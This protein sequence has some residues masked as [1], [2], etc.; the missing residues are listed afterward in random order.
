MREMIMRRWCD[1]CYAEGALQQEA[2]HTYTVGIVS[3]EGRPAL[4]VLEVCEVHNKTAVELMDLMKE[5]GQLPDLRAKAEPVKPVLAATD[6]PTKECPVCGTGVPR[7]T[8]VQHVWTRH[9]EDEKPAV[10][11]VCPE[12]RMPIDNGSGMSAHRRS[13]HGHSALD[14]ALSGVK[15]YKA[16]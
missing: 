11:T 3:G 4:K 14:E 2:E 5:I 12:C 13:V 15:G 10:P 6:I 1:M 8:L 16:K 9:R 7:N